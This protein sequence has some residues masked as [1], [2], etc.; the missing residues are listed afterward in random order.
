VELACTIMDAMPKNL[1]GGHGC[2][3]GIG[4]HREG[5]EERGALNFRK[6]S[7]GITLAAIMCGSGY[8]WFPGPKE[9]VKTGDNLLMVSNVI[10]DG[11]AISE[12]RLDLKEHLQTIMFNSTVFEKI[13]GIFPADYK[14]QKP[15]KTD[16]NLKWGMM[17]RMGSFAMAMEYGPM[18]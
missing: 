8:S 18:V 9:V 7:A 6:T 10:R 17:R 14:E 13:G 2:V 15:E 4:V 12:Q 5:N 3:V 11:Q 1:C 16:A